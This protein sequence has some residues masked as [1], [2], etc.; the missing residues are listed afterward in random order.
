MENQT[1]NLMQKY[2]EQLQ[3]AEM[4][5]STDAAKASAYAN[6]ATAIA[7]F[8][9]TC[10]IVPVKI[11][12]SVDESGKPVLSEED[13]KDEDKVIA[14]NKAVKE[15]NTKSDTKS[16]SKSNSKSN[17]KSNSKSN[18]RSTSKKAD[19]KAE[20]VDAETLKTFNAL[21]EE[22]G[23]LINEEVDELTQG[24]MTSI[25]DLTDDLIGPFVIHLTTKIAEAKKKLEFYKDCE[26]VDLDTML[27][28]LLKDDNGKPLYNSV[29]DIAD[30]DIAYFIKL[31]GI[32]DSNNYIDELLDAEENPVS[33]D[34]MVGYLRE[35]LD[36]SENAKCS[37]DDI[38]D[39]NV[40]G[41]ASFLQEEVFC[42]Q[43]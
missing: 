26:Y 42:E 10:N 19:N 21:K 18:S 31:V 30:C 12:A 41:F 32:E 1:A 39:E 5:V 35:Y 13:L 17:T 23:D 14:H 25:D 29:D 38:T 8:L 15:S 37:L 28:E 4:Y 11:E 2:F 9:G 27:A 34:E 6:I 16:N 24:Q 33:E 3:N 36:L 20:V 40:V 7:T 22:F 43:E